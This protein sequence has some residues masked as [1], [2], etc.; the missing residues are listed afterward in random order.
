MMVF[1]DSEYASGSVVMIDRGQALL[2]VPLL[3]PVYREYTLL[4]IW[5]VI[6]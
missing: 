3:L 1:S 2:R 6:M 5:S 4:S